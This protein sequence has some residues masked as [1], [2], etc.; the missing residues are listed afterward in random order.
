MISEKDEI[1]GSEGYVDV[2]GGK[3]WYEVRGEGNKIPLLML[4][5]GPGYPSY[6]LNELNA[7]SEERPIIIFDQLGVGRSDAI[8]DTTL[9]TV[10]NFVDQVHRL[11]SKL[12]MNE[13]YL[14]GHSW[15]TML[16]MDY[17]LKHPS[18]YKMI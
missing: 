13:F 6:Y 16:A 7:L 17:Y 14:Y 11:V 5:G 9:M 10:D 2:T 18:K 15:G 4:H 8:T 3:I 1:R 12:E